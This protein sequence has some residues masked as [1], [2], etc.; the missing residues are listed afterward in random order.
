MGSRTVKV[1]AFSPKSNYPFNSPL[2]PDDSSFKTL[3]DLVSHTYYD[4][5][6]QLKGI[7]TYILVAYSTA[8]GPAGV[9]ACGCAWRVVGCVR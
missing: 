3:L 2:W 1:A 8:G 7:D 5:L 9:F 6:F 4:Q